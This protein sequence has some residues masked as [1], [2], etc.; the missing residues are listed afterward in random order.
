[1]A[2]QTRAQRRERRA[3]GAAP[4]DGQRSRAAVPARPQEEPREARA[5]GGGR[6]RFFSESYA[7][8]KKVEWPNQTQL[9]TG[10]N[11]GMIACVIVGVYLYAA[12]RVFSPLVNWLIGT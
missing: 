9:V 12:D 4:V 3:Q 11:V 1:M 6:G 8:L 7:E 10:T 2:R 5:T